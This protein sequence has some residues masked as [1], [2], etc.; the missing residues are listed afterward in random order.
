[1]LRNFPSHMLNFA[2]IVDN[3]GFQM[4]SL[5]GLA[6]RG[7]PRYLTGKVSL[8]KKIVLARPEVYLL[9][10]LILISELL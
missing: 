6:P 8:R 9:S 4:E 7:S 5:F 3:T 10:K 2:L 1:M